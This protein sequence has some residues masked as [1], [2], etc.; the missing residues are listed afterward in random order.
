MLEPVSVP[1]IGHYHMVKDYD[2]IFGDVDVA[3]CD[4]Y[5]AIMVVSMAELRATNSKFYMLNEKKRINIFP[6]PLLLLLCN[7]NLLKQ[8]KRETRKKNLWDL[9]DLIRIIILFFYTIIK[10]RKKNQIMMTCDGWIMMNKKKKERKI[11]K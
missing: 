8:K 11:S 6:F 4:K 3:Y 9:N 7:V 2:I 5:W 1:D 10:N